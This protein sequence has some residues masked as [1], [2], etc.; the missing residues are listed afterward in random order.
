MMNFL[1][2]GVFNC[3]PL[4]PTLKYSLPSGPNTNACAPWSW[5]TPPM[6]LNNTVGGPS[7]LSS[8]FSSVKS[9]ILGEQE[10]ITFVPSTAMPSAAFT[11]FP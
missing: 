8:P 5:S 9:R 10:T 7:A 11:S 6:P 4:L 2:S 3:R 1:P